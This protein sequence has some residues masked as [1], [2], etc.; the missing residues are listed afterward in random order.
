MSAFT[1]PI[2]TY[3]CHK[4]V[5][6]LKIKHVIASPRGYELHFEN[7]SFVPMQVSMEWVNK[8]TPHTG[9]YI[10]WY[11]NDGYV[12]FS[13]ASAFEAGYT[14]VEEPGQ[15]GPSTQAAREHFFES[16]LGV[17]Y[18]A[19]DELAEKRRSEWHSEMRADAFGDPHG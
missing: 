13:P 10:V 7:E 18:S 2:P 3:Q 11:E 12:S 4:R 5:Q 8:H 19:E 15:V 14:L 16:R 17:P 1:I 6:A 9:G